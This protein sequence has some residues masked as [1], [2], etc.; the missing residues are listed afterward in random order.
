MLSDST[1]APEGGGVPSISELVRSYRSRTGESLHRV[2]E[3]SA[4][5]GHRVTQRYLWDLEQGNAK[6]WPKTAA[7]F[8]ALA[9]GLETTQLAIVLGFARE[10]SIPIDMPAVASRMPPA[11]DRAP[12]R[13][14]D[15]ILAVCWAVSTDAPARRYLADDA[16]PEIGP[17]AGLIGDSLTPERPSDAHG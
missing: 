2:S 15:A 1:D 16:I 4:R 13:I 6:A 5:S 10:F 7:T 12:E 11:L 8:A 3:R 17:D 9:E 14:Q